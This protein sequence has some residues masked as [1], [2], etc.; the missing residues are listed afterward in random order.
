[1]AGFTLLELLVVIA[2]LGVLAAMLLPA[3]WRARDKA[4][5]ATCLSNLRQWGLTLR[6]YADSHN[7]C[8]MSGTEAIWAR[9]AWVLSLTNEYKEGL[10]P[11]RC[12]KA[13]NRRG[14]GTCESCVSPDDPN[15]SPWGGPTT[16][17]GFPIPDPADPAHV[18]TASYGLN[19]W[20]YNPD[21]NNVQG[22]IAELHWRKY[23]APT[24]P[25]ITPLFLDSMWRG[26]GPHSDDAPPQFNGQVSDLGSEMSVF[27]IA[28]HRKGVNVL[29]FDGS[30]RNARAKDLW[31]FPWHR[32]YDASASGSIAFP[33]WMN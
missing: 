23:S 25:A 28:R 20:V 14:P 22:R 30:V 3:L 12:A 6:I 18:L 9:G 7:D 16:A 29:F 27:A 1:V 13:I 26:G 15:A 32:Q 10:A 8:F 2:I 19:C 17:Y 24:E 21:T 5:N 33:G 31:R 4:R 11:L